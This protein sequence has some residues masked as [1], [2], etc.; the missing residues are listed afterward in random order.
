MPRS[1]PTIVGNW[2]MHKTG[3]EAA[4]YIYALGPISEKTTSRIYVAPAFTALEAASLASKNKKIFIGAQ[5]LSDHES[6]A[7]TGEISARML[8]EVGVRFVLIGHSERR[9]IFHENDAQI[10]RKVKLAIKYQFQPILCIGET[11]EE[12]ENGNTENVL[13][14]QIRNA[15]ED[16][17]EGELESLMLA[18]EPVWAIGT[19]LSATPEIAEKAHVFCRLIL[20]NLF[21]KEFADICAILYGG[22]VKSD[23]T[24]ELLSM[25]NIDGLLVGGASLEVDSFAK[26]ILAAEEIKK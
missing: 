16:F 13:Q 11:R 17:Q 1:V 14:S 7:F 19:G 25:K 23:N 5:N 12:R 3:H 9:H 6:G 24:K 21:S 8:R 2:K 4:E 22:S 10:N 26:I 18:Y 20:H 15:L